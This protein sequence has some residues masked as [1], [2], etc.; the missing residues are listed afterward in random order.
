MLASGWGAVINQEELQ[1]HD[2]DAV[3]AKPYQ[4]DRVRDLVAQLLAERDPARP[5]P[6]SARAP[7]AD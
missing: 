4:L 5:A 3:L 7:H 1:E 6:G 2:V